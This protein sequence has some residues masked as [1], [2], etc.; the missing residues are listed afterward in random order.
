MRRTR[1]QYLGGVLATAALAGCS[2]FTPLDGGGEESRSQ[3]LTLDAVEATGSPAGD[4]PL[5]PEGEPAL[6]DYFATWCAPCKPQMA[7]LRA[8]SEEFPGLHLVSITREDDAEAIR[9]FWREYDG[10]W[11]VASNPSL[12]AFQAHSV[13]NIPTKVLLSR[14]GTEAWRHT[15][16]AAA[17]AITD[18]IK[19]IR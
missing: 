11:P 9:T 7:E 13:D 5:R 14:D 1:R 19:A 8:V 17:S 18:E 4:V 10:T 15:G 3:R 2:G 16:L 6:V 12:D